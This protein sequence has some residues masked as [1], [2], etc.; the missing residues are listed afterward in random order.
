MVC[1]KEEAGRVCVTV[2]VTVEAGNCTVLA[3]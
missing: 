2:M 1:V 3:G